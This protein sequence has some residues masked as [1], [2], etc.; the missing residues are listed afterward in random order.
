MIIYFGIIRTMKEN[1]PVQYPF[2]IDTPYEKHIQAIRLM[3]ERKWHSAILL[4]KELVKD[5]DL[6][7]FMRYRVLCD[8]ESVSDQTGD[9]RSAYVAARKKL[10]LLEGRISADAP[11]KNQ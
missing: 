5:T 2:P 11:F 6:P 9:L 8:L 4:L 3:G 7:Y 1:K 10:E